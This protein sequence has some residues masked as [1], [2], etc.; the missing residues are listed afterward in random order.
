MASLCV[1]CHWV[2]NGSC[3]GS[4]GMNMDAL[5]RTWMTHIVIISHS[6]IV[7]EAGDQVGSAK[8]SRLDSLRS[9]H[10]SIDNSVKSNPPIVIHLAMGE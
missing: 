7:A 4:D 9:R 8:M 2:R 1:L 6:V 10:K 3:A 5:D